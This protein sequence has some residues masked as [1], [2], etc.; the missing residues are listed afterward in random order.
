MATWEKLHERSHYPLWQWFLGEIQA[1]QASLFKSVGNVATIVQ[2]D[3][4]SWKSAT[5]LEV[6]G[7]DCCLDCLSH[8]SQRVLSWGQMYVGAP[9][10]SLIRTTIPSSIKFRRSLGNLLTYSGLGEFH[11]VV[12]VAVTKK[13][14][15][16]V[17]VFFLQQVVRT[18]VQ[19]PNI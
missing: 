14:T 18:S 11:G 17:C 5:F 19:H 12:R 7:P 4:S 16:H 10:M 2:L 13:M 1:T 3:S 6:L 15:S 8:S 9:K